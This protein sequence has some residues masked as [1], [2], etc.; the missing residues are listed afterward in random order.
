MG[1]LL[2]QAAL[3]ADETAEVA[4]AGLSLFSIPLERA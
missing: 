1:I 3:D 4:G 2:P